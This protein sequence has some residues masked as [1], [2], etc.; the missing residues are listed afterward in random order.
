MGVAST[1]VEDII[2]AVWGRDTGAFARA[3]LDV[4]IQKANN[5]AAVAAAV[6]GGAIDIGKSSSMGIVNARAH[7]IPVL[8]VAACAVY[9]PESE[10]R[11]SRRREGRAD[12]RRTRS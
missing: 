7:G 8:M 11:G 6:I 4:D 12:P 2:G 5:G 3:G 9:G 10:R 1:T